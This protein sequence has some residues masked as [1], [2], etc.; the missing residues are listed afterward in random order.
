[1]TARGKTRLLRYSSGDR[2]AISGAARAL[3]NGP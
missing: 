2:V 1:M 3:A